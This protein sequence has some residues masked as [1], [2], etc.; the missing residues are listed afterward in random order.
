MK[1]TSRRTGWVQHSQTHNV[2]RA[3]NLN[4]HAFDLQPEALKYTIRSWPQYPAYSPLRNLQLQIL[5][6]PLRNLQLQILPIPS[7]TPAPNLPPRVHKRI[8]KLLGVLERLS[9]ARAH[10]ALLAR[11]GHPPEDVLDAGPVLCP[12][13]PAAPPP[14]RAP[15]D[16]C[17][18]R[19]CGTATASTASMRS[20]I[21]TAFSGSYCRP[22][23]RR[24]VRTPAHLRRPAPS[25]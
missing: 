9:V 7:P 3:F 22:V 21:L 24:P 6:I 23:S 1:Q 15:T 12:S 19:N 4:N 25:S 11:L 14:T 5:S 18:L 20:H 17:V 10:L 13:A 8:H 16:G 2:T